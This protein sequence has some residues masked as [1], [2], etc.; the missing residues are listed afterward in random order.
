MGEFMPL[1]K[2]VKKEVKPLVSADSTGLSLVVMTSEEDIIGWDRQFIVDVLLR[3]TFIDRP[4]CSEIED[5]L[6]D[7]A[8]H[9][10]IKYEGATLVVPMCDVGSSVLN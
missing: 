8:D 9:F 10:W 6:V 5:L 3:E 7:R 1:Q 2:G 4:Y